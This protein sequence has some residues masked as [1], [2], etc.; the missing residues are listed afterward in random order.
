MPSGMSIFSYRTSKLRIFYENLVKIKREGLGDAGV[1]R[2]GQV[3][4]PRPELGRRGRHDPAQGQ[5]RGSRPAAQDLDIAV[6]PASR[7]LQA[8]ARQRRAQGLETS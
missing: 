7:R 1:V 5:A 6:A 2:Q 3:P 8:L 4:A